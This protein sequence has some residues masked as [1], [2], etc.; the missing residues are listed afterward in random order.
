[1]IELPE[2]ITIGLDEA[3][4]PAA[5]AAALARAKALDR[6]L[7]VAPASQGSIGVPAGAAPPPPASPPP[8]PEPKPN[9]SVAEAGNG[10]TYMAALRAAGVVIIKPEGASAPPSARPEDVVLTKAAASDHRVWLEADEKARKQGGTVV[11]V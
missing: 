9:L 8:A 2:V 10:P 11:V 1:M 4:D 3:S 6:P 5:F 7:V